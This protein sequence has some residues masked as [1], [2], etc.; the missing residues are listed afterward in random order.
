MH[1]QEDIIKSL[2]CLNDISKNLKDIRFKAGALSLNTSKPMILFDEDGVPCDSYR[3]ERDNAC[4]IVEELM[5]LA[6]MAAAE[7]ISNA[8]PDC[9]LLRRHPEP[10]PRDRKSV[11]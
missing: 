6:N 10:N 2:R 1:K 5:L 3:C 7:V 8:F 9:A 4:F 11:V